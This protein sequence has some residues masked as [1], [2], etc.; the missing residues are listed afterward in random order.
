[1]ATVL[2]CG[3]AVQYVSGPSLVMGWA[4][5]GGVTSAVASVSVGERESRV[6]SLRHSA[7]DLPLPGSARR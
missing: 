2:P 6:P 3:S 5:S 7:I 4:R 1:M